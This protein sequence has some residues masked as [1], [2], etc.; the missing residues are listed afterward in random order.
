MYFII[1]N[2]KNNCE[3]Y[4][5]NWPSERIDQLVLKNK[6]DV[7]VISTYSNTIKVL[8][9]GEKYGEPF[10]ETKEYKIPKTFIASIINESIR[11]G[12]K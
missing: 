1:N 2:T 4:V 6:D 8:S 5:G 7:I 11:N 10:V 3:H 9:A 12:N